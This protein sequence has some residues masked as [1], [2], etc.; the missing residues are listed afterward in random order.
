MLL[1]VPDDCIGNIST[2][3]YCAKNVFFNRHH[4]SSGEA[5]LSDSSWFYFNGGFDLLSRR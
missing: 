3:V 5:E 1:S 4:F 2:P